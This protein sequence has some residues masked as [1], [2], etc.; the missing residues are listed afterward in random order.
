MQAWLVRGLKNGP[1]LNERAS[2][3]REGWWRAAGFSV[4]GV[5]KED[6]LL[7]KGGMNAGEAIILTKPLG[8][9]VLL[10]A[11]MR[12]AARGRWISGTPLLP[13]LY[14]PQRHPLCPSGNF[15]H[16]EVRDFLH[17]IFRSFLSFTDVH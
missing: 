13:Q 4:E 3:S 17:G 7:R 16:T 9:G 10:A 15:K 2:A 1:S 8:T 11:A 6:Q 5:V 12:G 14:L